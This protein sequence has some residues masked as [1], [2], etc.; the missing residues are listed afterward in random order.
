MS[1]PF[2]TSPK[3]WPFC[4]F[5]PTLLKVCKHVI[6]SRPLNFAMQIVPWLPWTLTYCL[7][8]QRKWE[9]Y[10]F[11]KIKEDVVSVQE[12]KQNICN[13]CHCMH[14]YNEKSCYSMLLW[15][16]WH[17]KYKKFLLPTDWFWRKVYVHLQRFV[18][19]VGKTL[20]EP[21]S[22]LISSVCTSC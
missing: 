5:S 7:L 9:E 19:P 18:F 2:E 12:T 14:F 15:Y 20:P 6:C 17:L 16:C 10:S 3:L 21:F 13:K 4:G 11:T 1:Y 22:S 8:S